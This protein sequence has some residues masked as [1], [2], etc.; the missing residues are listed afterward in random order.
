MNY[1]PCGV[2]VYSL[3][4]VCTTLN[5]GTQCT[6]RPDGQTELAWIDSYKTW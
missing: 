5:L 3:V 4:W 1:T 6:A 2:P